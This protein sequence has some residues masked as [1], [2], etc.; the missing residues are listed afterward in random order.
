MESLFVD[1]GIWVDGLGVW[2]W[3]A[4][5]GLM[6]AAAILPIPAEAPAM[7]NGML[8][9]P[10]AG[11]AVT[12]CGAMLGAWI[13]FELARSLGRPLAERFLKPEALARADEVVANAGWGGML[14][15]RFVPFIAFT[16]LNWGAGLTPVSRW[17]FLWTTGLGIL[18]GAIVFTSSGAGVS[19]VYQR[20]SPVAGA[21]A[22]VALVGILVWAHR[23]RRHRPA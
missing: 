16:A 22:V 15:A 13:S 12:W 17:R 19:L 9:G 18:P 14:V 8:F 7:L 23:R 1:V 10:L 11:T 6:A 4:A 3:V 5:P 2:A 20:I 21:L